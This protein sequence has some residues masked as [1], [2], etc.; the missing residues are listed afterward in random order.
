MIVL[1]DRKADCCGCAACMNICPKNAIEMEPDSDGFVFPQIDRDLC[2]ECGLCKRVCAFQNVPVPNNKPLATYVGINKN[3]D[4]LINSASGG[5]FA[6]LAEF[7]FQ[8]QGVVFGCAYCED[9][10]PKHIGIDNVLH[11]ERIQGSKY[12]QSEINA[13]YS[14]VREY[15]EDDRWVLFTGTPCQISGLKSFLGKDYPQLL[16]ADLICHGV[17]SANFFV[18]YMRCLEKGIGGEIIDFNFRDK[19]KG[20]GLNSKVIYKR[21]NEMCERQIPT[22]DSYYYRYFLKGEIYRESCYS[23]KYACSHR[24]AD[25]TMGDYWGIENAHPEV[26]AQKGV[27]VLL[28]N[29]ERA[30]KLVEKLKKYLELT[31]SS[32]ELASK[33]NAQ[34]NKPTPMGGNRDKI[35]KAWRLGGYNAVAQ[36]YYRTHKYAII[37]AKIKSFV[38]LPIKKIIRSV[39]KRK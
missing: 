12:V 4:V 18:G 29:N 30:L 28:V 22:I 5:V 35:F 25:F 20:W 26:K 10:R 27:S 7:I 32:L 37:S 2:I 15:L 38:P 19:T 31:E 11:M 16:T 14:K 9:M 36:E 23:C 13:S 33:Q 21:N 3:T 24:V 1:F 8:R 34:L 6:A 17:P 39:L